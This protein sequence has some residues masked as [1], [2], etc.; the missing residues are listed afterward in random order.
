MRVSTR[1]RYGLRAMVDLAAHAT[2]G[3]VA[4]REIA[5]RQDVSESYLEQ[6][7]A[8]LR[9]AGLIVAIR[10]PQGGYMLARP[11]EEISA[12]EVLRTLEGPL[13]PVHCADSEGAAKVCD[14]AVHCAV[15]D[16]WHDLRM[17]IEG[18]LEATSLADLAARAARAEEKG[19]YHI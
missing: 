9:K 6:V 7:F 8:I 10:G 12:G 3:P 2:T 1:G 17:H 5:A 19:M 14:R 13:S 11:A 4:L 15:K 16:F 18:F